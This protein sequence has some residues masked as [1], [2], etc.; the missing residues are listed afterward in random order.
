VKLAGPPC[1]VFIPRG[2]KSSAFYNRVPGFIRGCSG[3]FPLWLC[4]IAMVKEERQGGH[5]FARVLMPSGDPAP[6]EFACWVVPWPYL[7]LVGG[8]VVA[9]WWCGPW[10][11]PDLP[12]P[13]F[14]GPDQHRFCLVGHHAVSGAAGCC[15]AFVYF[16]GA[17][18]ANQKFGGAQ[19]VGSA[20][21]G[22]LL[23][24]APCFSGASFIP[25]KQLFRPP[26]SAGGRALMPSSANI[27]SWISRDAFVF[28]GRAGARWFWRLDLCCMIPG[29]SGR[30][31]SYG[32]PRLRL[33]PWL[34]LAGCRMAGEGGS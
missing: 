9:C 27:F 23:G 24:P 5:N 25:L 22:F 10:A 19:G 1:G 34:P 7:L 31:P 13:S 3:S 6:S 2:R 32:G 14:A 17:P 26:L 15:S 29:P 30:W 20:L 16:G 28:R 21:L 8:E 33:S 11:V 4:A 18:S 12:T